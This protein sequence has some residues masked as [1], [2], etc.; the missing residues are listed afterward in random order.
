[1]RVSSAE[2]GA[3]HEPRKEQNSKPLMNANKKKNWRQTNSEIDNQQSKFVR[4]KVPMRVRNSQVGASHEPGVSGPG[5]EANGPGAILRC[6]DTVNGNGVTL[7]P[8]PLALNW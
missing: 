7:S 4:F 2:V 6:H 3:S 5:S 8:A 1:M